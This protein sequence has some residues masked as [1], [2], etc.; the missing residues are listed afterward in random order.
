MKTPARPPS[1]APL[2]RRRTRLVLVSLALAAMTAFAFWRVGTFDF[3]NFDDELY[4]TQNPQVQHGLTVEGVRWAFT[5]FHATNWHPLT[6]LSHMLDCQLFG[7]RAGMHHASSLLLHVLD[8][9]LL[10][11][12][13]VGM[14]GAFWRGALVAALFAL[15]PLHVESVAW[16][17]ERKDVLSAAFWLLTTW[18]Y[19]AYAR[20]RSPALYLGAVALFAC[21]VLAKPMVVSLPFTLLLLDVWPLGRLSLKRGAEAQER[22][23]RPQPRADRGKPGARPPGTRRRSVS[24]L[25]LEKVPFFALAAFS[26]LMTFLAQHRG[27]AVATLTWIPAS[28]RWPNAVVSYVAYLVK[29]VWPS[30]LCIYYPF[31]RFLPPW[32]VAGAG[33]L[34]VIITVLVLWQWRRRPYLAVG[35]LWYVGT[36]LPVIG[37]VQV[38]GQAMADRYTYIPSTGIF[39][40]VV[41]GLAEAGTRWRLQPWLA[42][43]PCGLLL[44]GLLVSTRHQVGFWR[45]S[46]TVYQRAL[47]VAPDSPLMSKDYGV[48]LMRLGKLDEARPYLARAVRLD[49]SYGDAYFGLGLVCEKQRDTTA[50]MNSYERALRLMPDHADAHMRLGVLLFGRGDVRGAAEHFATYAR[51]NPSDPEGHNNLGAALARQGRYVQAAAEFSR[52]VEIRPGYDEARNN[53]RM[54]RDVLEKRPAPR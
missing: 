43:A 45:D 44:L 33:V 25:L 16:V 24:G 21:G 3:I 2:Q 34:L 4:V 38:G 50:A 28:Q 19:V 22:A 40:L 37:L 31:V 8:S 46:V 54:A 32:K 14:T 9:L 12:L 48:T 30:H 10:F 27:G 11:W 18:A 6:W 39:V 17:A 53:L 20:R 23:V 41:W 42:A 35:W 36:L 51:L 7:M 5:T 47:T 29:L 1:A 26:S 15:H 49:P 13:L 52:A